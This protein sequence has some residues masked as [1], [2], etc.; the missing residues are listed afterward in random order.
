MNVLLTSF[1]P[2]ALSKPQAEDHKYHRLGLAEH[3]I[4]ETQPF[5]NCLIT[6]TLH[7]VVPCQLGDRR[8]HNKHDA[9]TVF[10][11]FN[12]G[13]QKANSDKRIKAMKIEVNVA[14]SFESGPS[15][16]KSS[17]STS[18]A[19]LEIKGR[20]PISARSKPEYVETTT[21]KGISVSPEFQGINVG[22]ANADIEQKY[23]IPNAMVMEAFPAGQTGAIWQLYENDL[24]KSGV[25]AVVNIALVVQTN[26][27]PF[28]IGLKFSGRCPFFG[29]FSLKEKIA[30]Q[31]KKSLL[32]V[33]K[34]EEFD[35]DCGLDDIESDTF[36]EWI[37]TETQNHWAEIIDYDG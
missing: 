17:S 9:C 30:M 13:P 20:Y 10:L 27:S 24:Y 14:K 15:T 23:N 11:Q 31:I 22:N 21:H 37:K 32:E 8:T 7:D 1:V 36:K 25:P 5:R 34:P 26:G 3:K 2:A 6:T 29:A 12:F 4:I 33:D 35:T 18:S 16:E 28:E 19:E